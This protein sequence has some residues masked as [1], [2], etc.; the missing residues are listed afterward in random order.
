M[1]IVVERRCAR[2]ARAQAQRMQEDNSKDTVSSNV[3]NVL[4]HVDE[5]VAF[6]DEFAF[7]V[8]LG[9]LESAIL[10]IISTKIKIKIT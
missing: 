5:E 7:F 6:Q 1:A 4:L 2:D 9:G 8:L 3:Y 10:Y